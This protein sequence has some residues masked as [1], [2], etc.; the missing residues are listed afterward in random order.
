MIGEEGKNVEKLSETKEELDKIYKSRASK[1]AAK[2]KRIN[3]ENNL[4]DIHTSQSQKKF[5][6]Q[7]KIKE[8]KIEGKLFTGTRNV[9]DGIHDKMKEELNQYGD[10]EFEDPV[11]R[12]EEEFLKEVVPYGWSDDEIRKLNDPT[13]EEEIFKILKYETNLDSAPGEDGITS[14][15]L[16]TLWKF[17]SFRWIYV[18]FLNFTRFSRDFQNPNNTGVMIVKNKKTQSIKY[19]K[20]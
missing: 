11:S 2:I 17:T 15:F 5:E 14:R 19:E 3:I 1:A 8:L 7:S 6:N 4:Y 16:L 20:K 12:E 10:K 13:T 18:R 9:V